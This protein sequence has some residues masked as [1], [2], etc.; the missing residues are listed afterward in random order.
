MG[1]GEVNSARARAKV[2]ERHGRLVIVEWLGSDRFRHARFRCLCDC[3]S[4][5]EKAS[6]SLNEM[7]SCGCW[8]KER[9]VAFHTTHG[10]AS[11]HGES[12]LYQLWKGMKR[13]CYNKIGRDYR[14]YGGKGVS[15]CE[16]WHDFAAFEDD[17]LGS[18]FPG[19]TIDRIN[20]DGNYEPSNC[21]WLTRAENS[22]RAQLELKQRAERCRG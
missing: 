5:C 1:S 20:P 6:S 2:G 11:R 21:R 4:T 14:W 22:R 9:V 8:G 17:V 12:P 19:A 3:G 16:R 10:G 15:V 13:R 18:W 7:A